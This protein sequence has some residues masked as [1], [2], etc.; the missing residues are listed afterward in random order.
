MFLTREMRCLFFFLVLAT[1]WLPDGC[2]ADEEGA[3]ADVED[4][5]EDNGDDEP[6]VCEP[7]LADECFDDVLEN[8]LCH[9]LSPVGRN[10][11]MRNAKDLCVGF[12]DALNCTSGIIDSSCSEK[13]G[14]LT[15][16]TWLIG[17]RAVELDLCQGEILEPIQTLLDNTRCWNFKKFIT[18]IESEANVTHV[19]DLLT[20]DLDAYECNRLQLAVGVCNAKAE[21][22][23]WFCKGKAE[24]LHRALA[25]FFS[26][27]N[28]GA[29]TSACRSLK[30]GGTTGATVLS[31]LVVMAVLLALLGIILVRKGV[32]ALNSTRRRHEDALDSDGP[33]EDYSRLT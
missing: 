30:M 14:R 3:A 32:L 22:N 2:R 33:Q 17:L 4:Q 31:T 24:V 16:D 26:A 13:E 7:A 25:V 19:S 20:T 8:I 15:F 23:R 12:D 27:T 1:S 5:E 29:L 11:T 18:C 28:C 21:K 10:C 6:E 9:V